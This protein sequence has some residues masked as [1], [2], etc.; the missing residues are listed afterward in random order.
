MK[1]TLTLAQ[2]NDLLRSEV[3]VARQAA[4]LTAQLV[5]QQ[6]EETYRVLQRLEV[7][8]EY[9][10]ALHKTTIS[11]MGRLEVTD[12]LQTIVTRAGALL[13]TENGFIYLLTPDQ[14]QMEM[15]VGIGSQAQRVG[16]R[17][18]PGQ[19]LAG[20]IW[21]SG[22]PLAVDDY[23]NWEGRRMDADMPAYRGML[24]APL[25]SGEQVIG[26]ISLAFLDTERKIG[27]TE[28]E[29]L[30]RFAALASVA[31]DNAR[32]YA[33]V[34]QELAERK[35]AEAALHASEEYH[36]LLL[37]VSP[38][39]MIVYDAQENVLSI[40]RTFTQTFGWRPEEAVG[41]KIDFVPENER[42]NLR[43]VFALGM[44]AG[45]VQDVETKSLT[46]DGREL[47]VNMSATFL[48]D[49]AGQ[50]S[51]II[52]LLRD[53]TE[54]KR[55][56]NELRQARDAAESANR[57]KS[58]FLATMS[59]EIRTP[60]NGIIGMTSLLM[61]TELSREQREYTA[62]VRDSA[63]ALL[64]IINDILD[65]SKIEAGRLD[66]DEHPF[67]L[68]ECVE[69]ALEMV[70]MRATQKGID[71]A[72]TIDHRVPP[73]ILGDE[74]R[75]RQI[76]LNLLSN[77][78]KFTEKGEVII[79]ISSE[80]AAEPQS[81][82]SGTDHTTLVHFA[83]R[84]SGI[85]IPADRLDRLFK[86]FSQV[87]AS[88]TRKYGGT[89]L[90]LVI[91]KR[92]SEIMGGTMWVDSILHK[93]S[94]FHFTIR[95]KAVAAEARP[96]LQLN[97]EQLSGKNVLIVDDNF[98]NLEILTAQTRQWGM[99]PYK[100]HLP[101][102]ALK[103]IQDGHEFDVALL[104]MQMPEM[105][106]LTLALQIR[107]KLDSH[108]LPLIMITSLGRKE[109][110]SEEA[111]FAAYLYKPIRLSQL[112]NILVNVFSNQQV[113]TSHRAKKETSRIDRH[114]AER[115]PLRILL[116]EDYHINQ[117][118]ALQ[119]LSKMGYRADLA[120]NGVEVLQ[121]LERQP[122][123]VILMDVQMPEMDGLEATRRVRQRWPRPGGP[124]IIA[125]TA[126]AMSGD[127][128]KCLAAGMDDYI[129]KPIRVE[130]LTAA[131]SCCEPTPPSA[132]APA[133][134][135]AAS[136]ASEEMIVPAQKP[137]IDW[138]VIEG[139]R[140]MMQDESPGFVK[141]MFNL[142]LEETPPLIKSIHKAVA[143]KAAGDLRLHA[144]SLKGSSNS[145]GAQRIATLALQ[146]ESMG[147]AK[148]VEGADGLVVELE[149]EYQLVVRAL[150]EAGIN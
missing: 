88:T 47:V 137:A 97:P 31:L 115:V 125:L 13:G 63:D 45:Q 98:T 65:F 49:E 121:A 5:S 59:H 23:R 99:I 90:G 144:H 142:Y 50:I 7:A 147:K 96:Y 61:D 48:K 51:R 19:G 85:G 24:G 124:R 140:A 80:A 28:Q 111:Q 75:V 102:Q 39:P 1:Q 2:E 84:D 46:K 42:E 129:G 68:Y 127:R 133:P 134:Q 146:L 53:I 149:N 22:Q 21:A 120:A 38:E 62:T 25:K 70:A 89:G 132:P 35:R 41:R 123:D 60:M 83:V 112:H 12:L 71:L 148:T 27:P 33:A 110:N 10:G 81:P 29:V 4:D 78:V 44:Q 57:A 82:H 93:G 139:L 66:L 113:F 67:D 92:L 6:F 56:E 145:L 76:L 114:L 122:Y 40:N 15:R 36:R 116:A 126:E 109:P 52:L 37:D 86:S 91:S 55:L 130:E 128:E 135:P 17:I 87:D 117:R 106:G 118:L 32:L 108:Q 9:L 105:D 16:L 69:S 77:A 141:D 94:T 101:E 138:S 119:L 100:T 103:W 150:Q 8:N 58:A 3:R 11:L 143:E 34:Q 131:L 107:K 64:N 73:N 26:V 30:A 14:T 79:S 74:T 136:R 95:V 18:I 72:Y 20:K 43:R 104:D 54:R